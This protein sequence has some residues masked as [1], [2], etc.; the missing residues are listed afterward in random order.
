[1]TTATALDPA[2]LPD[3]P[4]TLKKIILQFDQQLQERDR[5][6]QDRYQYVLRLQHMLAQLRRWQFG[7]KAERIPEGQLIFPFY[8]T[9]ETVPAPT[10]GENR[11]PRAR[12]RPKRGGYRVIPKDLP[13]KIVVVDLPPD[14]KP[15]SD[16]HQERTLIGYDETRQ[17]DFNPASFFELVTRRAKY[18]CKPCEGHLR[19]APPRGWRGRSSGASRASASWPR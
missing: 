10:G 1:M 16:C 7:T 15:C 9:L 12:R 18:A 5:Q 11:A 6:L 17:L 2:T 13:Q 8:G 19:T 4:E 14:Q 3:D